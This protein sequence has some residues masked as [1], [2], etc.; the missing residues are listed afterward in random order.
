MVQPNDL[1]ALM[2]LAQSEAG[3]KLFELLQ[4]NGGDEFHHAVAQARNGDYSHAQKTLS[5]LLQDPEALKLLR[6]LGGGI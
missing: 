6:Q 5:S 2:A 1:S 4:K 3:Q